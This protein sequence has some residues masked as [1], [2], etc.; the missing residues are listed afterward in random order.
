[1]KTQMNKITLKYNVQNETAQIGVT[2]RNGL[3]GG[4]CSVL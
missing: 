2:V 3:E 1:M 4:V